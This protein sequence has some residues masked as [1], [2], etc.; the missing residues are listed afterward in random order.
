MK[1]NRKVPIKKQQKRD[2]QQSLLVTTA[3]ILYIPFK[4]WRFIKAI[5]KKAEAV[6]FFLSFFSFFFF[7]KK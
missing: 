4:R 7:F 2:K 1:T 5:Q 6:G 3:P